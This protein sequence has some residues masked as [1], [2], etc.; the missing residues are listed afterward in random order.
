MKEAMYTIQLE[1]QYSKDEIL[2][3]YLNQ[4]YYGHGAYGIEAA[5]ELYFGKHAID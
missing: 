4:I 2:S 3:I 5:A 1:M